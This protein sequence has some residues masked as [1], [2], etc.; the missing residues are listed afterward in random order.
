[1]FS[2][3]LFNLNFESRVKLSLIPGVLNLVKMLIFAKRTP[4]LK[5]CF[6]VFKHIPNSLLHGWWELG[7]KA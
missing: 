6:I 5:I 3:L 4:G 7:T 1:M 2:F